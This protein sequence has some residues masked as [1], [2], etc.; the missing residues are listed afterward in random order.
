MPK[1]L[2]ILLQ[3]AM[4]ILFAGVGIAVLTGLLLP[5]LPKASGL[6]PMLGLIVILIGLHRF[7]VSR[8]TQGP[9][10]RRRYGGD[11]DRPWEKDK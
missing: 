10:D 3:W 2:K 4:P 6:R 1:I 11:T 9:T 5:Q 8:Y 7:V